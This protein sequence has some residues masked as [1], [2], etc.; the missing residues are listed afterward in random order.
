M[1]FLKSIKYGIFFAQSSFMLHY[2]F[3]AVERCQRSANQPAWFPYR[4]NSNATQNTKRCLRAY[5]RLSIGSMRRF[6]CVRVY[7]RAVNVQLMFEWLHV[8]FDVVSNLNDEIHKKCFYTP[9]K[10]SVYDTYTHTPTYIYINVHKFINA[11][12]YIQ[13]CISMEKS[14]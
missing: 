4:F 9:N 5:A 11:Y 1:I 2:I 12:N 8:L 14:L 3:C 6:V 10:Y 13:M 7:A